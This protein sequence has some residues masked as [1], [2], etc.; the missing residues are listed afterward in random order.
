MNYY[1]GLYSTKA[2]CFCILYDIVR[3]FS[4]VVERCIHIADV[5]GSNPPTATDGFIT[6]LKNINEYKKGFELCDFIK[7]RREKY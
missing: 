4:S 2:I 1:R 7:K 6:F 5:G 3:P